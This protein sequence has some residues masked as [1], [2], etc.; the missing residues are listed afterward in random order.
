MYKEVQMKVRA[1]ETS[2][3]NNIE[4]GM[5]YN[6]LSES[7]N[8]GFDYYEIEF[9]SG[10]KNLVMAS[11]FEKLKGSKLTGECSEEKNTMTK[12]DLKTGMVVELED[13]DRFI[14]INDRL[15]LKS[16]FIGL[17]RFDDRMEHLN[18]KNSTIVKVFD[19][20]DCLNLD[21]KRLKLIWT[22]EPSA[23]TEAKEKLEEALKAVEEAKAV[24]EKVSV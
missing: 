21:N 11:R 13:G 1:K 5:I 19:N 24:L 22:R 12:D 17:D 20:T 15:L 2:G 14:V 18:M 6:L 16:G 4:K 8:N 7:R 10:V 3:L 9:E 23:L